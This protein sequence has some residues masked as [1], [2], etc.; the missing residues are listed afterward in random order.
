MKSFQKNTIIIAA[1]VVIIYTLI[2]IYIMRYA[3][4]NEEWPPSISDCPDYWSTDCSKGP[5]KC[6]CVNSKNLG[7]CSQKTMDFNLSPFVG[8]EGDCNKYKWASKC[9][10]PWGGISYGVDNPCS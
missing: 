7:T 6:V 10:I 4:N 5:D 9:G 8:S 2:M 1:I 3:A